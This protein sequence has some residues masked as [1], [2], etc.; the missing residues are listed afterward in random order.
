MKRRVK[1]L[2]LLDDL[3]NIKASDN[4]RIKKLSLYRSSH[5]AKITPEIEKVLIEKYHIIHVVDFRTDEENTKL[6]E[7]EH[8]QIHHYHI[9]MLEN[10]QNR[11]ITK[12]NR[13]RILKDMSKTKGGAKARMTEFYSLLITSPKA[14]KAYRSF[15]DILLKTKENEGVAFHCTQGKDRTG[16]AMMLLLTVLGV[17][18]ETIIKEYQSYNR[19]RWN[20]RFWVSVGMILVKSP[21][22]AVNLDCIIGTRKQYILESYNTIDKKYQNIDN[23]IENVIGVSKEEIGKL[24]SRFLY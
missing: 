14:Q 9:P 21:K 13:L 7:L 16:I 4:K 18:K 22:L 24:R 12:E 11:M 3:V 1:G 17:N 2:S 15:F 10:E 23:Y 8:S 19:K 6:P 5:F 20:F